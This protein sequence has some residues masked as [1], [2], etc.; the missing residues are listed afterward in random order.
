MAHTY[1]TLDEFGKYLSDGG[2]TPTS[3][4]AMLAVL[5]GAS[6]RIDAYCDRSW[7]GS[8]FGSRTGTNR[9]D[10]PGGM[11][12]Q[13]ADDLQSITSLKI[14]DATASAVFESPT[15]DTDYYLL[16]YSG[17]PYTQIALHG[18]GTVTA[19][20][21]GLRTVEIAGTWGFSDSRQTTTATVGTASAS[22]TALTLTA[23]SAVISAGHTMRVGSEDIYVTAVSSGTALTVVRGQ[24]GT[25]AAIIPNNTAASVHVYPDAVVAA[26]LALAQRRWKSRDAGLTGD[27]GMGQFPTSQHR[28]S[29]MSVLN[30]HV[31]HL[32]I[33]GAR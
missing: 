2:L 23:G 25:T 1:A 6:R 12:L 33:F 19:W 27:F 22:A 29:E 4:A 14:Y 21:Y 30:A 18:E 9:Y 7:F 5:E 13:L 32:R 15:V 26:C 8:G 20:T 24:N 3:P 17:P 10:G 16:P 11:L 28:D 31:G